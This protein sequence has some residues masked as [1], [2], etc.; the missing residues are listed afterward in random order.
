MYEK[1]LYIVLVLLSHKNIHL[2][3]V[4]LILLIYGSSSYSVITF[5]TYSLLLKALCKSTHYKESIME[6]N[7][8]LVGEQQIK[9]SAH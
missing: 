8:S 2:F 7:Y 1:V 6:Y 5:L 3:Y 9:D 4:W